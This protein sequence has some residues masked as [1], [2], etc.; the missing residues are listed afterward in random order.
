MEPINPNR[1][2]DCRG[3]ACP[4]PL[5]KTKKTMADMA[6]GEILEVI[7]TDPGSKNDLPSWAARTGNQYLGVKEEGELFHFYLQKK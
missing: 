5:L 1:T 3:D 2:L 4:L 7:G 6:S